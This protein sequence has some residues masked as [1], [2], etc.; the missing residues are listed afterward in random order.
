MFVVLMVV[1]S[2][3]FPDPAYKLQLMI[4]LFLWDFFAEGTKTGLASLHAKAFLF[5]KIRCRSGCWCWPRLP[6]R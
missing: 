6:I 2:F 4:G 5:T 3:V 1:F